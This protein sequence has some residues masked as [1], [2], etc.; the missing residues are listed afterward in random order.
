MAARETPALLVCKEIPLF[1]LCRPFRTQFGPRFKNPMKMT[2][3]RGLMV[4]FACMGAV[5]RLHV[6][7]Y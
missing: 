5:R 2:M 3:R 6:Q 1:E 4:F 7:E